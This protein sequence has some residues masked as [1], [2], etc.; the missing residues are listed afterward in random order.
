MRNVFRVSICVVFLFAVLACSGN[1]KVKRIDA[2]TT[3]DLSG[4]WNDT[5]VRIVCDSLIKDALASPRIDRYISDFCSRNIGSRPAVIVGRFRNVTSEHIDTSIISGIMRTSILNSGKL[6]FVEGG[7]LRDD[8]RLERQDQ[9]INASATTAAMLKNETG[10][11]FML[12]GTVNSIIDGA[13][14]RMT[15]TYYVTATIVDIET[16]RILWEGENNSI[17]KQIRR[18][19]TRI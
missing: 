9:Q 12:V 10:A 13:G 15:R 5:D 18:P 3:T 16:N 1:P 14:N 2:N 19:G 6:D 4:N 11:D 7:E 17:K 8:I